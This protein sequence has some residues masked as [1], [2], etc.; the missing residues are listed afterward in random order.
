MWLSVNISTFTNSHTYGRHTFNEQG[1]ALSSHTRKLQIH[2]WVSEY[3][4]RNWHSLTLLATACNCSYS[5]ILRRE[6]EAL[7]V[8]D[9]KLPDLWSSHYSYSSARCTPTSGSQ[10]TPVG[11]P[12]ISTDGGAHFSF[13]SNGS[14]SS[15]HARCQKRDQHCLMTQCNKNISITL[16]VADVR[17]CVCCACGRTSES[18]LRSPSWRTA[19]GDF[20]LAWLDWAI[21]RFNCQSTYSSCH[22]HTHTHTEGEWATLWNQQGC[23]KTSPF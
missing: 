4:G 10:Q 2:A 1:Q 17:V 6:Q 14:Q 21:C 15:R 5:V 23:N 3:G 13:G 12:F 20:S 9:N 22:T 11:L 16:C 18:S 19:L 8:W 7:E